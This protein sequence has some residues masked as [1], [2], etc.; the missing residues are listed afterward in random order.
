MK[1]TVV[2]VLLCSMGIL[3]VHTRGVYAQDASGVTPDAT[4]RR[5]D[6]TLRYY[7]LEKKLQEGRGPEKE[8]IIDETSETGKERPQSD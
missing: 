4:Q 1:E 3:S 6:E 2:L 8:G 7:E 5:L